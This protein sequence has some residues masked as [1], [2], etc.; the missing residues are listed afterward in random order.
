[1]PTGMR[2]RADFRTVPPERSN[3]KRMRSGRSRFRFSF[4]AG[5]DLVAFRMPAKVTVAKAHGMFADGAKCHE[6]VRIIFKA[7]GFGAALG[8]VRRFGFWPVLRCVI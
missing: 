1:M 5:D 7:G 3:I 8:K 4:G 6:A 2:S